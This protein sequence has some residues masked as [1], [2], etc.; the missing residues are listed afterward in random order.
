MQV[1]Y[2]IIGQGICG[3]WLTYFLEKEN[4]SFII[5][6]DC[7]PMSASRIAAGIINPVTGRRHVEVWMADQV[8]PFAYKSYQELGQKI[9]CRSISQ[10]NIIDFFPSPQMRVSFMQRVEEENKYVHAIN[11]DSDFQQHFNFDFGCGQISPVYIVNL[12]TILPLWRKYLVSKNQLREET[13]L[14]NDLSVLDDHV[15]YRDIVAQKILFCDGYRSG[16]RPYFK[17]LPFGPN[18]G[19]A[20]LLNIE[21]LPTGNIYKKGLVLAPLEIDGQWW[22]GSNYGWDFDHTNPTAEFREHAEAV[23]KGWIREPFKVIEHVA[24][25]RPATLERRPFV[26]IHPL[27]TAVGIL[28]GMGTKGC[29]LAPFFARQLSDHLCHNQPILPDANILRF[30]NILS[31]K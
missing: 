14:E 24:G 22:C 8:L 31:R 15:R 20:L 12:E 19:E 4:K 21:G 9:N 30:K 6:D 7:Q 3:T 1:D 16:N 10:K 18:K 13:F 11:N 23:L 5:I 2:L 28:N 25:V 17:T 26:G 29:S 27:Y